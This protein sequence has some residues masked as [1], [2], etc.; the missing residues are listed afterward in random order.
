MG[1]QKILT[2]KVTVSG[3]FLFFSFSLFF[4]YPP[5]S[6]FSSKM[7]A[8]TKGSVKFEK[9]THT[10]K[11]ES[12]IACGDLYSLPVT[13]VPGCGFLLGMLLRKEGISRASELYDCYKK[14]KSQR[15][16]GREEGKESRGKEERP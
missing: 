13:A 8:E 9:L 15:A 3:R 4:F 6:D 5:E 1:L 14:K 16:E 2:L 11:F 7:A 10:K 12:L